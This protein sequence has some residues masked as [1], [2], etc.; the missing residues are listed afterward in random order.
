VLRKWLV[1]LLGFI[2]VLGCIVWL[3]LPSAPPGLPAAAADHHLHIQGPAATA[4][5]KR[6][7]SKNVLLRIV[8][9]VRPSALKER[10][11]SEALHLLD[12]AGIRQGEL[13]SEAYLLS[14]PM[15]KSRDDAD[16]SRLTREENAFN[17]EAAAASGG[18]LV[19][20]VGINPFTAGA[21]EELHFWA[22]K[23]GVAGVKLHLANSGFE[24]KSPAM[25]ATLANFVD[26]ARI[27]NMPLVIHVRNA[28]DYSRIDAEIFINEVLT[29]AGD[30]SVQI[31]HA[32][33]WGGLDDATLDAL[34]AYRDA[35]ANNAS[36]TRNLKFDLA[37][38]VLW[39]FT[40]GHR[41]QTL[42]ALMREIGLDR[43]LMASDWPARA[44]PG[45]YNKL[46]EAQLPLTRTEWIQ[47]LG[48]RAAPLRL[49][50]R[51]LTAN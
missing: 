36:G 32:G 8:S 10:G 38:V 19:A 31:A 4:A 40:N 49:G 16:L 26:E 1:S 14:T 41:L 51:E 11:G 20:F 23:P 22:G 27:S 2:V 13:L 30:L 21:L 37:V 6:M 7:G 29:H 48:N 45:D 18:R 33:G 15:L 35:I 25:V 17:V 46:L 3:M 9:L 28:D 34:R 47:V 12:E 24:P 50:A 42:V 43:F 44:S 39:P 5:L